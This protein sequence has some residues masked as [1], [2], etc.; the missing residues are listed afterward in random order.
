M[1]GIMNNNFKYFVN[2]SKAYKKG[3]KVYVEGVASGTLE[4]RDEERMSLQ[5]LK[6]FISE[7]KTKGLPLTNSHPRTGDVIGE[8]GTVVDG[9]VRKNGDA[10]EMHIKAE[11]DMDNPAA[12]YMLKQIQRGKKFAFSIE[13]SGAKAKTVWSEK[14]KKMIT[15]F[16]R[17]IPEAIS[18]TT[19]PSYS[20]SFLEVVSKSYDSKDIDANETSNDNENNESNLTDNSDMKKEVMKNEEV[21]EQ[22]TKVESV[23]EVKEEV[24][25]EDKV[26]EVVEEIKEEGK[27]EVSE[28][29]VEEVAEEEVKE[30]EKIE[31]ALVEEE[32]VEEVVE[33]TKKSEKEEN[34]VEKMMDVAEVEH[35]TM[36]MRMKN[37]IVSELADLAYQT[38]KA[39]VEEKWGEMFSK[40]KKSAEAPSQD[41]V[42]KSAPEESQEDRVLKTLEALVEVVK[43]QHEDLEAL[44]GMPLQKKSLGYLVSKSFAINDDAPVE[45]SKE[46]TP[47]TFKDIAKNITG[48]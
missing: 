17:I 22:T 38:V 43:S 48:E 23:E 37:M 32:K 5:V 34:K 20:P 6:D 28:E 12:P 9:E 33:E 41:K 1:K 15:E 35:M 36:E 30:E 21:V 40:A 46:G 16:V 11:V 4:D 26:E 8:M 3:T 2:I 39:V 29:P 44:K 10:Y 24:V 14:L 27:E 45:E 47:K 18:I 25:V 13:G 19:Q 31:E 7:I 42:E